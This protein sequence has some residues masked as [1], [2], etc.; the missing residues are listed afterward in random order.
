MPAFLS[1]SEASQRAVRGLDQ[2]SPAPAQPRPPTGRP[3]TYQHRVSPIPRPRFVPGPGLQIRSTA[4]PAV[5]DTP[6][7]AF[8]DYTHLSSLPLTHSF[9]HTLTQA[10]SFIF[11]S[12]ENLHTY[13]TLRPP[14]HSLGAG[15]A[16]GPGLTSWPGHVQKHFTPDHSPDSP[17][18]RYRPLRRPALHVC[19]CDGPMAPTLSSLSSSLEQR[20]PMKQGQSLVGRIST[21]LRADNLTS[22]SRLVSVFCP[23]VLKTLTWPSSRPV[24]LCYKRQNCCQSLFSSC[25]SFSLPIFLLLLSA[26]TRPVQ[27]H[28]IQSFR[29]DS[30][31]DRQASISFLTRL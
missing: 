24:A 7:P 8:R 4:M 18:P 31:S 9:T 27:C 26:D 5:G 29:R 25:L 21:W 12:L 14:A 2:P 13:I 6:K 16:S 3:H 10:L 17:P 22:G 30:T 19:E 15:P 23:H 20:P 28:L 11:R 1:Q